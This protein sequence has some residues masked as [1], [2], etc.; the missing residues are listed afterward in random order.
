MPEVRQHHRALREAAL[1]A[2]AAPSL[3]AKT[4]GLAQCRVAIDALL[5]VLSA[6]GST[7]AQAATLCSGALT[8]P[9]QLPGVP[10][11]PELIAHLKVPQR[12]L[13][14]E[15]GLARLLHA[16]AH[17]EFNAINL[18]LDAVWRFD[19]MPVAFYADWL[20]V[21]EEEALHFGLLDDI[22]QS[23]G[24]RYGDFAAHTGL[25][26]MTHKTRHD[27][28]A[29][30]ALVPRTLEA[31]GLDAT[32]PMQA[33]LRSVG[34]R[35]A[36]QAVAALDIILR[37]EIGHVRIGNH[38]YGWLCGRQG[39]DPVQHYAT[40]VQ[41][42]DAPKLRAPFNEAARLAA[43]FSAAELAAMRATAS[44]ASA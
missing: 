15:E 40:L 21:A 43:G 30:M 23:M 25:W 36:L 22:L 16:V 37:D 29:R 26:D 28:T 27:I 10:Q 6:A 14:S 41:R 9:S 2:L 42:Y 12:S 39:L 35:P 7:P 18:A 34:S 8:E 31:R 20:Q 33:K 5:A 17:I 13:H 38:W 4:A 24:Y 44:G 19:G 32:P 1:A 11:R 3:S